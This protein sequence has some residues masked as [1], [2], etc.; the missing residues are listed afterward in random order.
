M[1][2]QSSGAMHLPLCVRVRVLALL[3]CAPAELS[4]FAFSRACAGCN[5]LAFPGMSAV[6][7]LG[8]P[9][10]IVK[11]FEPVKQFFIEMEHGET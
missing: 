3:L 8:G 6:L 10:Q 2:P 7:F 9:S 5:A 1:L 11:N 4:T